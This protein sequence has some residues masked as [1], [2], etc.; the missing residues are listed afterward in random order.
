[1][2]TSGQGVLHL[3]YPVVDDALIEWVQS[4]DP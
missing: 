4:L 3:R 2:T 1:M